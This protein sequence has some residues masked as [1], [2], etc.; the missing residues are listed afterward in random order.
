MT[1]PSDI[2]RRK[3]LA[4][5]LR[6]LIIETCQIRDIRAEDIPEDVPII[7]GPGP[8]QLDSLDALQI[9]VA[10][11]REFG[12][13]IDDPGTAARAFASLSHLVDFVERNATRGAGLNVVSESIPS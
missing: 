1:V 4:D 2:E 6:C 7:I 3:Q 13:D 8:L 11:N 9:T 12:V 10:L 5:R